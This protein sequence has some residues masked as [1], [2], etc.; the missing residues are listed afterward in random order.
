MFEVCL[1]HFCV[2]LLLG[3]VVYVCT[4]CFLFELCLRTLFVVVLFVWL[5]FDE[6]FGVQT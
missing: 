3:T 1:T 4:I 5:V 6:L 2:V